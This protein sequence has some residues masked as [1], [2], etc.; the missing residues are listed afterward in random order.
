MPCLPVIEELDARIFMQSKVMNASNLNDCFCLLSLQTNFPVI[1]HCFQQIL[2][3]TFSSDLLNVGE[4][5]K[6]AQGGHVQAECFTLSSK[7]AEAK[8][9]PKP[10]CVKVAA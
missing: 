4:E 7:P 3:K 6:T 9:P 2:V 5:A 10:Q 8:Q 1:Y